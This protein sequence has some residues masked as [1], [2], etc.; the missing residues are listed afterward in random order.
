M[1]SKVTL[2]DFE[3]LSVIGQVAHFFLWYLYSH[4]L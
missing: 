1:E 3:L 2:D 4:A